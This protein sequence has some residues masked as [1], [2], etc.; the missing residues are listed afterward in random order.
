MTYKDNTQGNEFD[1][2]WNAVDIEEL[3]GDLCVN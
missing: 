3:I 1:M 2:T